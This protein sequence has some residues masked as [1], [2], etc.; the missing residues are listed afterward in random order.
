VDNVCRVPLCI[1]VE[2]ERIFVKLPKLSKGTLEKIVL[3]NP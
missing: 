3:G 2:L 1:C